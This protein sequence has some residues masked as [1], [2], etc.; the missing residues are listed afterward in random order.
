MLISIVNRSR[1]LAPADLV[2]A[3]RAVNAQFAHDFEPY[4]QFGARLVIEGGGPAH[5]QEA[6]PLK[7]R[8]GAS[9]DGIIYIQD[10]ADVAGAEGFH[11]RHKDDVPFGQVFLDVCEEVGDD[12]TVALSH[13]A[14]ELTG[15]PMNNL[16]VQGPHPLDKRHLVF[17][18]FELCDAVQNE[19]YERDGVR[20]SNFV[21]PAYFTRGDWRGVRNDFLGRSSRGEEL[22]PFGVAPGGYL[23]F[24][25]PAR[26][27]DKWHPF[28][29]D[30]DV[31]ARKRLDI[32]MKTGQG[33][34]A[35]RVHGG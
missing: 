1:K 19:S 21:L 33:R 5:P 23:C 30:N 16:L 27:G 15:D 7:R 28:T 18:M 14:I 22:P 6:P 34:I 2:R 26:T 20:V 11:D 24:F 31:I 12:W 3:V 9:H 25:D 29:P 10:H 4:W 13:E 32:K 8:A 17:H 35:R